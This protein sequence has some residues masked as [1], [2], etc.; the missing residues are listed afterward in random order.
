M[1]LRLKKEQNNVKIKVDNYVLFKG[2]G[3]TKI[4]RYSKVT[5]KIFLS[6]KFHFE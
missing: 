3:E 2:F 5:M 6:S 4:N 1:K